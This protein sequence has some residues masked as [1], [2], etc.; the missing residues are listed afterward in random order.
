[1]NQ[2]AVIFGI[3]VSLCSILG[4]GIAVLRWCVKQTLSMNEQTTMLRRVHH[5][6]FPSEGLCMEDRLIEKIKKAKEE[7]LAEVKKI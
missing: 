6:L 1:M 2:A 3:I 7:V 4:A 5:K